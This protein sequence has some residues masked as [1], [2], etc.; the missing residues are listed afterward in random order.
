[1]QHGMFQG[2]FLEEATFE[3]TLESSVSQPVGHS[4]FVVIGLFHG[5]CLRPLKNRYLYS[6]S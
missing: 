1:M 3:L 5:D 4:S 6:D 2:D